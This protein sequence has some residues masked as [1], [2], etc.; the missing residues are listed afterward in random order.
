MEQK[1]NYTLMVNL[2]VLIDIFVC[3]M[4][5]KAAGQTK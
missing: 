2:G 3:K 5:K 4:S 1:C